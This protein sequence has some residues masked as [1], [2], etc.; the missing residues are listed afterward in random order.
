MNSVEV[1]PQLSH[2]GHPVDSALVG[3]GSLWPVVCLT[4]VQLHKRW[5]NCLGFSHSL[6]ALRRG[7]NDLEHRF[8][9]LL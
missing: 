9:R 7:L 6:Y 5:T 4:L 3:A 8:I 2:N 1:Y